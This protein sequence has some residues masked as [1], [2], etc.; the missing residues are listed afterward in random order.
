MK[1]LI[2]LYGA[3]ILI[4]LGLL[5]LP[6]L[7]FADVTLGGRTM[8]PADNLF[9][10][11]PWASAAA[12]LGVATPH[13]SL[14]SDLILENYVWKQFIRDSLSQGELPLWSPHLFAGSPFLATGQNAAYYP[15]SIFFLLL[16]L[17]AA[18]GWY[19]VSQLWLAGIAMYLF[20]RVLRMRR[21]SAAVAA[22]VFQGSGF[23]LVSAAVFPMIIG[24]A[25]WLP[26]LLALVEMVIRASSTL[27]GAGKTLPWVVLGALALGAQVLAGHIEITYYTL[28]VMAAYAV[29]RLL[30]RV[31]QQRQDLPP[32]EQR[33]GT[34]R[35]M[36]KPAFWLL[37]L[38]VLGM[39][40]GAIQ[41][42]PF[43]E[44]GQANFREGSASLA[45]VRGWA[46]PPRRALTLF[47]PNFF[48][49]PAHHSYPDVFSGEEVAF[50]TNYY[51]EVNPWGAYSSDW[52]IKNYVEGGIY[53]GILPLFLALL[54]LRSWPTRTR[55]SRS[56]ILF[57]VV[58]SLFS[59][60]FI[61]GTP[62]YA[63]LYYG[64]PGINQLHSPFRWVFPLALAVAALAG[65]G[66]DFLAR[67][68]AP[69]PRG[70]RISATR[71]HDARWLRPVFLW[72]RPSAVTTLA[73]VAFWGGLLLLF[74][75]LLSRFSY[76][77]LE[78]FVERLFLGLKRAPDAFPDTRA[79]Y[80]YQF[81]NLLILAAAL[82]ATGLVLRAS[83]CTRFRWCQLWP[84]LAPLVVGVDLLVANAGFHTAAVPALLDYEPEVVQ[85][86]QQ[87][88][89]E[90][91]LTTFAPHGDKPL[92]ANAAWLYGLE[93][94]RGY[95]SVIPR[96]YVRFMEAV[97]P[98]S[99]L[100]F[101]RIQPI[102]DWQALNSPLLDVL[103]A[104]YVLTTATIDLPKYKLVWEGEGVRVYENL[105]AMPRAYLLPQTATAPVADPVAELNRL[106][107]RQHV[108]VEAAAWDEPAPAPSSPVAAQPIPA[109]I[110]DYGNV[111][112]IVAASA[113]TPSWL[114]LNDS[115]FPGWK[116]FLQPAHDPGADE[117]ELT[118]YPVNG[119]FRGVLL[120]P[121][122][123]SVR[124]RYSPMSFKL[125]GL[126]SA[127]AGVI[128][129]F[130]VGVWGWRRFYNPE[131]ELTD[132][133]S[134]AKNSIVPT[135]L[136]L[137]NKAIDFLYAAF[138][139]RVL[140]PAD[141]GAFATAIAIAM[142]YEILANFGLNT[143]VIR[144]VSRDRREG[145]RYLI[146]TIALRLATSALAL[147]PILLYLWVATRGTNA[148]S[149]DAV[150]AI[151]FL[152]A[153]MLFSGAGQ[154]FS[155]LFYAYE[156]AETPA[157]I[158]TIT[159]ILKVAFGVGALLLGYSYVGM[160]AVS[161]IVNVI[162]LFILVAA[163]R[164][165]VR[166]TGPWRLDFGLQR[167]MLSQSAP[168]M[169]N[170][171]LA[172]IFF[173]VDVPLMQRFNGDEA[174]GWYNSAYKW[175]MAINVIPSFFTMALFP[176]ISRQIHD[177]LDDARRSF[178]MAIKL[179]ALISLPIA[180]VT[181]VLAPFFIGVLGGAEF[182]PHG[183]IA[184][185]I[186]IWSIPIGWINSVTN[187][188]LIALGLERVQVRAFIAGVTFNFVANLLLLP[189]YSYRAAALTTI[190]SEVVLLAIF[191]VYL[192]RRMPG[193]RWFRLLWRPALAT[194][195]MAAAFFAG[196]LLSPVLGL[197]AALPVY[198][199]ALWMLGAL[200]EE[201]RM[202]LRTLLPAPVAARLRLT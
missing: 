110:T 58:L 201:E 86:L 91:R 165:R 97:E 76:G 25:A 187:Y 48:G 12:E 128:L 182:L 134:V 39:M 186:V 106:D 159:T 147:L 127:M 114:V 198:P 68:R 124:F 109:T 99:E 84:W 188:T 82:L 37:A 107:P 133:R 108:L 158:A 176:V 44:V 137:F 35:A 22:L 32:A 131:A 144:E 41:F 162:T 132:T 28:L 90:W 183:A 157:A 71:L 70:P 121:G 170:H 154:S 92:N 192:Q 3:D 7:L 18:Y 152:I 72:S 78:P 17:P 83:C 23:M 54:G 69:V 47:L 77:A 199:V 164:R 104:K 33:T 24:A 191:N 153:G 30:S 67:Q 171:L 179:M 95:D 50:N 139:L 202:V 1:R 125:G 155:G 94:V 27:R 36:A 80:S 9:Q 6:L 5:A 81:R 172:Q 117:Q 185:R 89:G 13:N 111:E 123:W 75:L 61:F 148:L 60:A 34:L 161:V 105:A 174:V 57:F 143:L 195:L 140:G 103:G 160:A 20:A 189:L 85:W 141:A 146:N 8:I 98:Q 166:L 163:T 66:M 16:P 167:R 168:L 31:W 150:L 11:A 120:P 65:Y 14:L 100:L 113:A 64:L 21:A 177:N 151:L 2:R 156:T 4:V 26:L 178:R 119:N 200:G 79:F 112:V 193:V 49:N 184:L 62:L 56:A 118:I 15:F 197:L 101:N 10:W 129:L 87:Q 59:L 136:N 63:L 29:W 175:V 135:I 46:F 102:R 126:T 142:W 138:Y 130:A 96:R 40:I 173:F 53:L 51:G 122:D 73:G 145:S 42:I 43:Y 88:P 116:A 180:L 45:E 74:G 149:R 181:T 38:V 115:Y 19:T 55:G 194:S 190:L 52:G 93:D 196:A 169:I